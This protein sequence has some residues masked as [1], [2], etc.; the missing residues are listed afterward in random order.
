M[1]SDLQ[2]QLRNA[3]AAKDQLQEQCNEL[4][5]AATAADDIAKY[6]ARISALTSKN[7]ELKTMAD[8]SRHRMCIFKTENERLRAEVEELQAA[9]RASEAS[10]K[11]DLVALQ[12][13]TEEQSE[14]IAALTA[15]LEKAEE[16]LNV[17]ATTTSAPA[18]VV[19]GE[20][21]KQLAIVQKKLE[22]RDEL[23]E[24]LQTELA[25]LKA[26]VKEKDQTILTLQHEQQEAVA[27]AQ[28]A[29]EEVVRLQQ[30]EL[31]LTAALRSAKSELAVVSSTLVEATERASEA[32]T[33]ADRLQQVEA[34]L[35]EKIALIT[36]LEREKQQRVEAAQQDGLAGQKEQSATVAALQ[37]SESALRAQI[38]KTDHAISAAVSKIKA[39]FPT[40][41]SSL[42]RGA[43][44][45]C[46]GAGEAELN[47]YLLV[48]LYLYLAQQRGENTSAPAQQSA[49]IS[50]RPTVIKSGTTSAGNN[51]D[52][53]VGSAAAAAVPTVTAASASAPSAQPV[54]E[55]ET[56]DSVGGTSTQ[57]ESAQRSAE[58][59]NVQEKSAAPVST[60]P[61]QRDLS[62]TSSAHTSSDTGSRSSAS[63]SNG[64]SNTSVT[65]TKDAPAKDKSTTVANTAAVSSKPG[66]APAPPQPAPQG[67]ASA[68]T[69]SKRPAPTSVP[70]GPP[71]TPALFYTVRITGAGRHTIPA[72]VRQLAECFGPVHEF[73]TLPDRS[74][75]V[76][77][78]SGQVARRAADDMNG[79]VLDGN[80]LV[81]EP[82]ARNE[83]TIEM[84]MVYV[85]HQT[86][87][88]AELRTELQ[89]YGTV[90][91]MVT[92]DDGYVATFLTVDAAESAVLNLNRTFLAN[93][94]VT[95]KAYSALTSGAGSSSVGSRAPT[96]STTT[97]PLIAAAAPSHPSAAP[98]VPRG[99]QPTVS[100]SVPNA[101][102]RDT[103]ALRTVQRSTS[104][105]GLVI[106]V[107]RGPVE[108]EEPMIRIVSSPRPRSRSPPR[109]R[110]RSRSSSDDS[111]SEG[112]NDGYSE[113]HN[114]G[115]REND[116]S[117]SPRRTIVFKDPA[118]PQRRPRS[119]SRS[120]SRER[121]PR[122]HFDI[123]PPKL[124]VRE[125]D[126]NHA[127]LPHD[128][129]AC[130]DICMKLGR[131]KRAAFSH[132][133]SEHRPRYEAES[134]G[135]NYGAGG[136]HN[137]SSGS[138][139]SSVGSGG[140]GNGGS[141]EK[142]GGGKY[143][144][145]CADRGLER[146]CRTHHTKD[147]RE[148][149]TSVAA[150]EQVD[151]GGPRGGEVAYART[152]GSSLRFSDVA[153]GAGEQMVTPR[154]AVAT[155]TAEVKAAVVP[156]VNGPLSTKR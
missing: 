103:A 153:P 73:R 2:T 67:A 49:P 122:P 43:A 74:F 139:G 146:A 30:V 7:A 77:F 126:A 11:E 120:N 75:T 95:C 132:R 50:S 40:E 3:I 101:S 149:R 131:G 44:L 33:T 39:A 60:A 127:G 152:N 92:H 70:S 46:P 32:R 52:V 57:V 63:T 1:I 6:E 19:G 104:G 137:G 14:V 98:P 65:T 31:Q 81:C 113:G 115:H 34:I 13:H 22:L 93:K 118:L 116:R 99:A 82:C 148:P 41:T 109:Q 97:A 150:P 24:E 62:D 20:Q 17:S 55:A 136:R 123:S 102:E 76:E 54:P 107:S 143:C 36:E 83:P 80:T 56:K 114:E 61:Q 96:N 140:G 59:K 134:A 110:G 88:Q 47:L 72:R 85:R 29:Q 130:C 106:G 35:K 5:Q 15:R 112:D 48:G 71:T 125:D 100:Q 94:V 27:A 141:G 129:D 89:R 58:V 42:L 124:I 10:Y 9:A 86:L 135:I 37:A 87:T 21:S 28:K 119:R 45:S 26:A 111:Y 151:R 155:K 142:E 51:G 53:G 108:I 144:E 78:V 68:A 138:S 154:L 117:R 64:T 90:E 84:R 133:T 121:R 147:H 12:R 156:T 79:M 25:E 105:A 23:V 128:D 69:T 145:I 16:Q 18:T 91:T 38:A 66:A 4:Q 8:T